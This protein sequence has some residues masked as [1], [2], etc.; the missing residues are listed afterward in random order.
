ME[1]TVLIETPRLVLRLWSEAEVNALIALCTSEGFD[2]YTTGRFQN[3]DFE[4]G[5][6]FISEEQKIFHEHGIGRLGVFLRTNGNPIGMCGLYKMTDPNFLGTI[7]I[8]Y[9]FPKEHWGNGYAPEAALALVEYGFKSLNFE[10]ISA[11][12]DPKNIR[13]SRVVEKIGMKFLNDVTYKNEIRQH[14]ISPNH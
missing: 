9:R 6:S 1:S 2:D 7:G 10:S 3:M 4:K 11:I 5:T 12:I 13:S 8:A 14:W